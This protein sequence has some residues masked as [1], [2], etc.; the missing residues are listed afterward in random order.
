MYLVNANTER[1]EEV[2]ILTVP[3]LF[4]T[5]RVDRA[6]LPPWMHLYCKEVPLKSPPPEPAKRPQHR[7]GGP[8][9]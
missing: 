9:R 8:V 6:T 5:R 3:G 2:E 7:K 4:T 1:L